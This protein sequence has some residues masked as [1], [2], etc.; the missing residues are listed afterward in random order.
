LHRFYYFCAVNLSFDAM[1]IIANPVYQ[2]LDSFIKNIPLVFDKEGILFYSARNQL[3]TYQ[4]EGYDVIVKSFKKPHFFNRI[5]YT[6]FR[7]SKAKR[8]YEYALR[9]LEMGIPTP[10]PIACIEEKGCG[11]ISRSYY[12]S[13]YEKNWEHIRA[14]ML[15]EKK[16]EALIQ[17]LAE[18]IS[19]VHNK[20]VHFLDMTPGNILHK[21]EDGK[22]RFALIDIN[23]MK[24]KSNLSPKERYQGIKKV[25]IYPDI[26]ASV[27]R[28][29]ARCSGIDE[30]KRIK[31]KK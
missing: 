7:R 4:V 21:K 30:K 15:G 5:V 29:Y 14:Y 24:F 22:F 9:L 23:R 2:P 20:G 6:F 11:L 8:S 25:S 12:I 31:C 26:V 27:A 13:I 18:F 16:E 19:D 28:E 17:Q 1:K 10:A 3:K